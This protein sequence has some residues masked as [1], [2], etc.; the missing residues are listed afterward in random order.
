[1]RCDAS[2]FGPENEG[3]LILRLVSNYSPTAPVTSHKVYIVSNTSV[4]T[5]NL[6][7]QLRV[8]HQPSSNLANVNLS[9]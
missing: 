8:S 7:A 2:L 1:M 6:T 3:T 4:R 5:T 9:H